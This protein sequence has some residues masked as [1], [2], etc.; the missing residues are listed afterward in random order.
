LKLEPESERSKLA[1]DFL[2]NAHFQY[3][4]TLPQFRTLAN[5]DMQ[6][7]QSENDALH[8]QISELKTEIVRLRSEKG[9]AAPPTAAIDASPPKPSPAPKPGPVAAQKKPAPAQKKP[10]PTA[11]VA[12][13]YKVQPGEGLQAI[14]QK[15]YGDRAKWRKILE[16]NPQ[17]IDA[18]DLK[19][20]QILRIP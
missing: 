17:L 19:P 11:P 15:V 10:A 2:S 16:A 13:T 14:A 18:G 1:A 7:M 8:R 9:K 20:G 5:P 12:R 6:K 4:A 3:V